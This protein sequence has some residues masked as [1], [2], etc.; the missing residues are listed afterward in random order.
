[1]SGDTPS[2][3]TQSA[4]T[5]LPRRRFLQA[6]GMVASFVG[7]TGSASGRNTSAEGTPHFDSVLQ[8]GRFGYSTIAEAWE[9]ASTGDTIM[10]TGSYD[11][12]E[13][14]E[15]FPIVLDYREKEVTLTGNHPS[16]SVIDAGGSDAN[17]IEVIGRGPDDYRNNPIVR[18]LKITG[19]DIGLRIRASPFASYRNLILHETGSHGVKI[20]E[21]EDLSGVRKGSFG[22]TFFNCQAWACGGDGFQ[23]VKRANPHGT[24]YVSCRATACKGVGFRLRGSLA[25][26]LGGDTQL[27]HDWGIEARTGKAITVTNTYVEGNSRSNEFPVE[28]YARG[29]PGLTIQNCYFHG[30]NPRS[31]PGHDY[32]HVQRGVNLY[33]V[34]TA[35]VHHCAGLRYGEGMIALL[36]CEDIDVKPTSHWLYNSDLLA[37]DPP[38]DYGTVRPRANGMIIPTD[39]R[40]V[41][42]TFEGDV[43]YH[44][45]PQHEGPA[46][47]RNGQWHIAETTTL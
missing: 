4:S 23:S 11:A 32:D 2:R 25:R 38:Q 10:V 42:G 19:G 17:V 14:G 20:D 21:F 28:L 24:H 12:Q 31:T 8:V 45:G 43:G 1:M 44:V 6:A 9:A 35:S 22:M 47:W 33:D 30:I 36:K 37:T 5:D 13:A 27:N 7:T 46:Y 26:I 29:T 34:Q 15:E 18:D 40:D 3:E 16:G 41:Q 39:L